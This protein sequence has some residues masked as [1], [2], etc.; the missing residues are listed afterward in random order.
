MPKSDTWPG[1][2]AMEPSSNLDSA[3]SC[4]SVISMN[5]GDSEDSMEHLT[6]EERACIMYLEETIEALEVQEDSGFS[7]DEPEAG[8]QADTMS[9]MR[10]NDISS[11]NTDESGRPLTNGDKAEHHISQTPEPASS[12][13]FDTN[14]LNLMAQ[15]NPPVTESATDG[16]IHPTATQLC[17]SKDED[18][19]L[20]IVPSDS[21]SP[22]QSIGAPETDV[23]VIPPP[24]AFMDE[25]FNP[26][27]PQ[28][29]NYLPPSAEI[30]NHQPGGSVDLEEL[31]RRA[32]E[33]RSSQSLP[34]NKQPPNNHLELS[35]PVV[36]SG[37]PLSP[38][39]LSP[40][41]EAAEPRTPPA[42]AP[43]PKKLPSNIILKSHKTGYDGS[44]GV[45]V[46]TNSDRHLSDPQRVR[47]EAL[48]K[49][50]LLPAEA[51]SGPALSPILSPKTRNS[52]AAPPSTMIAAAPN[53]PPLTPSYNRVHTP[54]P[55]SAPLHT[56]VAE[57]TAAPPKAPADLPAE[58]LPVPAAFSDT[59][60]PPLSDNILS[61]LKDASEATGYAQANTPPLTPPAPIKHLTPPKVF[62]SASLERSI[63]GLRSYMASQESNKAGGDQSPS[64]LR[65]NRPR[66]A[67]LGSGKEFIGAR[68]DGFHVG[69]VISKEPDLRRS[70]QGHTAF[71]HTGNS[72]KLP[73]SQGISVLI[74]PRSENEED[75]RDALKKLGLIRD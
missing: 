41:P 10:I 21:L 3:G 58:V 35:L 60:E 68:G 52:W 61:A 31:R 2:V 29:V 56:P 62:K 70:L 17:I 47:I 63:P 32:T 28:R 27:Q 66:P 64:Q 72:Q 30:H 23:G 46:S 75:R 36:S 5:S 54:P 16:K 59:V 69:H 40:P 74:C 26:P 53:T 65:N 20:K 55:A 34:V 8:L 42:V 44:S 37:P 50:G 14:D 13:A 73:R 25:P 12:P 38:P 43:R 11:F 18:G 19:K 1:G 24:S 39:P 51:D 33:Q 49:L 45:S 4:D 71:Q 9:H 7:N 67:S 22:D 48:R 6:A 57:L 15:L